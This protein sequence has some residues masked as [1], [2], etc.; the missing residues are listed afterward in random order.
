MKPLHV[1]IYTSAGYW[2]F[3]FVEVDMPDGKNPNRK[4]CFSTETIKGTGESYV[5]E[6]FP[7]VSYEI[8]K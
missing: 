7:G 3:I 5:K 1:V 2:D 6:H 8:V 4:A